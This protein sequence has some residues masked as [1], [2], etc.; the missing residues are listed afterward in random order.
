MYTFFKT[1]IHSVEYKE[2]GI[3]Y[4][5]DVIEYAQ[6][7]HAG[8]AFCVKLKDKL[9]TGTDIIEVLNIQHHLLRKH[10]ILS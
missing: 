9:Y 2:G 6:M 4:K 3:E 7:V 10:N 5:P 8:N 1:G